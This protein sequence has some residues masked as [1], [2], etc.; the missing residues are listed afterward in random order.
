M[1]IYSWKSPFAHSLV[2]QL[3]R[4]HAAYWAVWED[5]RTSHG[6]IQFHN[7][8]MFT[9]KKEEPKK[10]KASGVWQHGHRYLEPGEI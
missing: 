1:S 2:L 9:K 10:K 8:R 3:Q 7:Q 5:I 4:Q 6:F